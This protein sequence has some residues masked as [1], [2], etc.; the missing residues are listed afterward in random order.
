MKTVYAHRQPQQQQH[1]QKKGVELLGNG[2]VHTI[3]GSYGGGRDGTLNV[4]PLLY[5]KDRHSFFAVF[6]SRE[7]K[8]GTL[9][10]NKHSDDLLLGADEVHLCLR[11]FADLLAAPE[12]TRHQGVRNAHRHQRQNV[13]ENEEEQ[14][15]AVKRGRK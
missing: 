11:R 14:V 5:R 8:V 13:G 7:K 10:T 4:R 6:Q 9:T 12:D 3:N 2:K 1:R 15:V